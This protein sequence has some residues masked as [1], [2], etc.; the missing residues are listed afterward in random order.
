M[1][2]SLRMKLRLSW[3]DHVAILLLRRQ[4]RTS[5]TVKISEKSQAVK[6]I[7]NL[8][9]VTEFAF[10]S[11]DELPA[12]MQADDEKKNRLEPGQSQ[13]DE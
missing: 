11:E 13:N 9:D 4:I 2:R 5:E 1:T 6:E 3:Y 12:P 10:S 8:R 7:R